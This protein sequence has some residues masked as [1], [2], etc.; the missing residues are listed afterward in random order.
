[1]KSIKLN[2]PHA[3]VVIGAPG[4]GKSTFAATFAETFNAPLIDRDYF[5]DNARTKQLGE[6]MFWHSLKQLTKTE[7]LL[8]VDGSDKNSAE[9]AEAARSLMHSGY[10][11]VYIWVQTDPVACRERLM[12]RLR[13]TGDKKSDIKIKIEKI[14]NSYVPLQVKTTPTIVISGRHTFA[15]QGRTVLEKLTA[16]R[17]KASLQ[18][19]PARATEPAS[20][21]DNSAVKRRRKLY[22]R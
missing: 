12:K 20:R 9:R 8:V 5:K 10:K 6:E 19:A 21:V 3:L 14:L 16:E 1:M 7:K 11:V 22:I 13:A 18:P 17:P 2:S 4:S 15:T